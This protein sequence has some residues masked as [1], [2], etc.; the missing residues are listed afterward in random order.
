MSTTTIINT[1]TTTKPATQTTKSAAKT[2]EAPLI[3]SENATAPPGKK[4]VKKTIIVTEKV[5]RE[6]VKA[7]QGLPIDLTLPKYAE[8]KKNYEA[9][10]K[11]NS[12]AGDGT[13]VSYT[14][15]PASG[16][17]RR[18]SEEGSSKAEWTLVFDDG[19][20]VSAAKD[21]VS[22]QEFSESISA[23]TGVSV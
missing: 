10:F 2:T 1:T 13:T 19:A 6:T 16:T 21:L 23:D 9:S 20:D 17:R 5:V 18:L 12:G 15:V 14:S 7:E 4:V 11:K 3:V 22:S 8:D